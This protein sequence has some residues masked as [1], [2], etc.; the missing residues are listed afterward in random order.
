MSAPS[1]PKNPSNTTCV[2][3]ISV[4]LLYES[5]MAQFKL[6]WGFTSVYLTLH[7][8]LLSQHPTEL[9]VSMAIRGSCQVV[10]KDK[11]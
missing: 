8:H 1:E 4:A 2:I 6:G 7:H 11:C 3:R 10:D 5:R 9:E